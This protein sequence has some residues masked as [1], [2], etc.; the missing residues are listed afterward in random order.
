MI[1][2]NNGKDF[3]KSYDLATKWEAATTNEDKKFQAQLYGMRSAYRLGKTDA[4][5]ALADKVA[6][7]ARASKDQTA[8]ASFYLGK[9]AYDRKELD[10]A[11]L[12]LKKAITNGNQ[13]EQTAEAEYLVAS[14]DYQKRNLDEALR[15][16]E[17]ASQN[18]VSPYWAAKC[19]ILEADIYAEKGDLVNARAALEAVRD[20]FTD[21]PD[22]VNEAKRKLDNLDKRSS[23]KPLKAKVESGLM[24]MDEN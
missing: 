19:T 14:I 6:N 7:N 22:L 3:Q 4:V 18:S 20:N 15:R 23:S 17:K 10:K 1:A 5:Y 24:E 9:I 12:A 11:M 13:D 21:N 8:V 2:Y 16:C